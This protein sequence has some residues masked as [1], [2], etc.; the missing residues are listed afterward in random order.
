MLYLAFG[1]LVLLMHRRGM[2]DEWFRHREWRLLEEHVMCAADDA[3][4]EDRMTRFRQDHPRLQERSW[5]R[6][7][8]R[9]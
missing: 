1:L 3:E 6:F 5:M 2:F 4:W 9:R 7:G 8:T